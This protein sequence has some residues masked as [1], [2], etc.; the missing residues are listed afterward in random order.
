MGSVYDS[1]MAGMTEAIEDAK[2]EGKKLKKRAVST[3][4]V[5]TYS[6]KLGDRHE[7]SVGCS[8]PYSKHDGNG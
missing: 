7:S 2:G 4:P 1:I 3:E 6:A 8:K 5:K